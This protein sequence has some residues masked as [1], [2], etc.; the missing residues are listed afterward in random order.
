LRRHDQLLTREMLLRDV[1]NYNF[2]PTTNLIDVHMG[3]LRH[4]VDDPS[5]TPMIYNI[6]GAG[7]ILRETTG[8][9]HIPSIRELTYS[10]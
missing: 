10:A 2:V 9:P 7:F 5:E 8:H 1:W 3:R 4:K 6:R